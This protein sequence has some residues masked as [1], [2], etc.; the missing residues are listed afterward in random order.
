M[1]EVLAL[2][3]ICDDKKLMSNLGI[4]HE[5]NFSDT[6]YFKFCKKHINQLKE[7]EDGRD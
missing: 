1:V 6:N 4:V 7:T 5:W 2:C 3:V